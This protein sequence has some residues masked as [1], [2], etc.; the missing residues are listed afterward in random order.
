MAEFRSRLHILNCCTNLGFLLKLLKL[1]SDHL[2][3]SEAG[4]GR[5]EF[6]FKSIY[7]GEK[8]RGFCFLVRLSA[9]QG[10]TPLMCPLLGNDTDLDPGSQGLAIYHLWDLGQADLLI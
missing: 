8:V 7:L 9:L 1:S 6:V 4:V 5:E 2:V 3:S 10:N